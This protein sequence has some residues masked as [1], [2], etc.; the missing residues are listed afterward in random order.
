MI[1]SVE[2]AGHGLHASRSRSR[3]IKPTPPDRTQ[4]HSGRA[5]RRARRRRPGGPRICENRILLHGIRRLDVD[6]REPRGHRGGGRHR[7]SPTMDLGSDRL[8]TELDV[9]DGDTDAG[10][11]D[12]HGTRWPA[13]SPRTPATGPAPAASVDSADNARTVMSGREGRATT[14]PRG[15]AWAADHGAQ[16]INVSLSTPRRAGCFRRCRVRSAQGPS[17]RIGRQCRIEGTALPGRVRVDP[18]GRSGRRRP[19]EPAPTSGAM[20]RPTA[21]STR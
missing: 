4:N 16:V 2:Q 12:G 15:I 20:W 8:T 13:S 11:G 7:G 6:D 5:L 1:P 21:T 9:V 3:R 18:R 19:E 10:D 14:P 17:R